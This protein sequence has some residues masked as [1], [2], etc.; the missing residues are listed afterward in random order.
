VSFESPGCGE[1]GFFIGS[2]VVMSS[3]GGLVT[4]ESGGNV[5]GSEVGSMAGAHAV[6]RMTATDRNILLHILP[7]LAL[8]EMT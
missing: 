6:T 2:F 7:P 4:A 3:C 5:A 8:G 1:K